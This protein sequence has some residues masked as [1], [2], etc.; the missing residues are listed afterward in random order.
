MAHA[1]AGQVVALSRHK[2]ASNVVEKCIQFCGKEARAAMITEVLGTGAD[3]SDLLLTMMTDQFSNYTL[4][5]LLDFSDDEDRVRA[6]AAA[7]CALF[8]SAGL[9]LACSAQAKLIPRMRAHLPTCKKFAFGK[10]IASAVERL[11]AAQMPVL[12]VPPPATPAGEA[13]A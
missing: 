13:A 7:P 5:R 1:L 11:S 6:M 12:E 4:Q 10:H 2:F 3:G 9:T 8:L